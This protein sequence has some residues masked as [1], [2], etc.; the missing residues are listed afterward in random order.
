MRGRFVHQ[1][2]VRCTNQYEPSASTTKEIADSPYRAKAGRVRK[3]REK[4]GS[5]RWQP[6]V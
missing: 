5:I 1:A 2:I 6:G 3:T 4:H